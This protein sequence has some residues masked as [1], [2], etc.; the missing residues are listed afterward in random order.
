MGRLGLHTFG[1]FKLC[2]SMQARI[3][4]RRLAGG[5]RTDQKP[6]YYFHLW[7]PE[8]TTNLLS[9][10]GWKIKADNS[11]LWDTCSLSLPEQASEYEN[12]NAIQISQI[13]LGSVSLYG[14]QFNF[15][16]CLNETSKLTC[17]ETILIR[18]NEQLI[19]AVQVERLLSYHQLIQL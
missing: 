8:I 10:T 12:F 18:M 1:K 2:I 4:I 16:H 11:L 14:F 5:I 13:M 9:C 3:K 17:R 19:Y 15:E 7:P 6:N